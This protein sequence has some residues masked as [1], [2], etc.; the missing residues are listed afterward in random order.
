MTK[1]ILGKH[2]S[3]EAIA[4]DYIAKGEA[5]DDGRYSLSER[6]KEEQAFS[7]HKHR[8]LD[9]LIERMR[10]EKCARLYREVARL[11]TGKVNARA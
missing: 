9:T 8:V 3:I 11:P 10:A 6:L 4:G 1:A 7:Q 2:S 5:W